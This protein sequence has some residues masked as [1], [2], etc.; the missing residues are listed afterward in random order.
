M[1]AKMDSAYVGNMVANLLV[2]QELIRV[3]AALTSHSPAEAYASIA[4]TVTVRIDNITAG[5][6]TDAVQA[7]ARKMLAKIGEGI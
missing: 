6:D 3:L 1:T 4:E 7:N 5:S 2:T